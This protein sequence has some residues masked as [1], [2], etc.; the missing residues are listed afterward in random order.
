MILS[1]RNEN[2]SG[3]SIGIRNVYRRLELYYDDQVRFDIS[4][5]P[6][7]GTTVSF[8][9]PIKLLEHQNEDRRDI[10]GV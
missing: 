6:E 5:S 8:D 3:S 1:V 10:D 9:I 7:E 2:A 4:S